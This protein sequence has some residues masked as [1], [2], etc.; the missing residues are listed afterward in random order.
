MFS[1]HPSG[2]SSIVHPLTPL[3]LVDEFLWKMAQ[4]FVMW[5]GIAGHKRGQDFPCWVALS[6]YLRSWWSFLLKK[7][8]LLALLGGFTYNLNCCSR[9]QWG[10]SA[11]PGHV[12]TSPNAMMP[13]A[14]ACI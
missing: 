8:W 3:Y 13:E 2:C 12:M 5:V 11:P 7:F 1:G 4:I 14:M 9:P 10:G 6:L